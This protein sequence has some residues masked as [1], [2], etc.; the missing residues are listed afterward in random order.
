[1]AAASSERDG[2]DGRARAARDRLLSQYPRSIEAAEAR[3][4]AFGPADDRDAIGARP[5]TVAVVIGAFVDATRAR[6]LAA[7]AR[8]A[9]FPEAQVVSLG[10]GVAAVHT[11]RLG[12]YPHAAE[13]RRAGEQAALA[14]GVTYELTRAP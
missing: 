5:G 11:V 1:M 13:A 10:A 12:L 7:A 4:A 14:L 3:R 9:G 2:A 8:A 6:A